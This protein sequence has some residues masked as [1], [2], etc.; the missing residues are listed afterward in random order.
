MQ[1]DQ[2][3]RQSTPP[4]AQDISVVVIDSS[5]I[6][7]NSSSSRPAP[8]PGLSQISQPFRDETTHFDHS[9]V[10]ASLPT[11]SFPHIAR[12]SQQN[13]ELSKS[14]APVLIND[15]PASDIVFDLDEFDEFSSPP[16]ALLVDS[17]P[18]KSTRKAASVPP[19]SIDLNSYADLT[20]GD[21]RG[22]SR[23]GT[24]RKS[25]AKE[26]TLNTN[27]QSTAKKAS[28]PAPRAH[29]NPQHLFTSSPLPSQ[30]PPAPQTQQPSLPIR[31]RPYV[32]PLSSSPSIMTDLTNKPRNQ[33][34]AHQARVPNTS[35]AASFQSASL[36]LEALGVRGDISIQSRRA[37]T[38][39]HIDTSS[40]SPAPRSASLARSRS[41]LQTE[42]VVPRPARATQS[43]SSNLPRGLFQDLGPVGITTAQKRGNGASE[44]GLPEPAKKPRATRQPSATSA[45]AKE[46]E[47]RK[48]Q[49]RLEKERAAREKAVA[50]EL[51][52]VNVL[53]KD[54]RAACAELIID[55]DSEF[56]LTEAGGQIAQSHRELGVGV[57]TDWRSS[58]GNMI[59]WRRKVRAEYNFALGHFVPIPEE[60]RKE[61]F[62]LIILP[63]VEFVGMVLD[64]T[65]DEHVQ[66]VRTRFPDSKLIY[67]IE[68]LY[69]LQ[70]KIAAKS[71]REFNATVQNALR[72]AE[73]ETVTA[74]AAGAARS[75]KQ[76]KSDLEVRIENEYKPGIHDER[77]EEALIALQVRHYALVLHSA[78]PAVSAE[79]TTALTQSIG[80][81]PYWRAQTNIHETVCMAGGQVTIGRNVDDIFMRTMTQC[82][83]VTEPLA[84]MIVD[85]H[86]SLDKMMADVEVNGARAF[87]HIDRGSMTATKR[88]VG[89]KLASDLQFIFTCS[90]PDAL[91][92]P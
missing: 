90:D 67:M 88:R 70:N 80:M 43:E 12:A 54:K 45:K 76:K 91:L 5:P 31:P 14:P 86:G 62:L 42:N 68:G 84:R 75:R 20:S 10:A 21:E 56:A 49:K 25:M 35:A 66:S 27:P 61:Q 26:G 78:T 58:A 89:D 79:N 51:A 24:A 83:N 36:I 81:I 7:I 87:L 46:A 1:P 53:K 6:E 85:K 71:R 28:P 44:P 72:E 57:F 9:E 11:T 92:I 41:S 2:T 48:E 32:Q 3:R 50:K 23:K 4:S 74:A 17:P 16:P 39:E 64:E 82:K 65:I 34:P 59:K 22:L 52:T 40:S 73:G 30:P 60:I 13:K 63:D 38:V 37:A 8:S 47:A 18:T 77:I 19:A 69:S 15:G 29:A 33:S 55:I